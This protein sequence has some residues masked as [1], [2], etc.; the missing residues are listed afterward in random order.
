MN[1]FIIYN[2][3]DQKLSFG[4]GKL[5]SFDGKV[6]KFINLP[7][8]PNIAKEIYIGLIENNK[9]EKNG[10]YLDKNEWYEGDFCSGYREGYGKTTNPLHKYIGSF[11]NDLYEGQGQLITGK[12]IY[13]GQFK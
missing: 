8:K 9:F 4:K 11:K 1:Q 7:G 6:I 5:N 2:W 3:L 10:F 12:D 13:V